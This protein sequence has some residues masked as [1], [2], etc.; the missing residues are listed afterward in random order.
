[1]GVTV[2]MF[3]VFA[4]I[5]VGLY[6]YHAMLKRHKAEE[7][8]RA[9]GDESPTTH[10]NVPDHDELPPDSKPS[11]GVDRRLSQYW[12]DKMPTLASA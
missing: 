11:V 4:L 6:L 1:M 9:R 3:S 10:K 7:M 12:S 5:V 2:V 8:R